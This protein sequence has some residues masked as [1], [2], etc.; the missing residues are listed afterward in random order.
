MRAGFIITLTHK[1]V[2]GVSLRTMMMM[3]TPKQPFTA[4]ERMLGL[5]LAVLF[6][7]MGFAAYTRYYVPEHSIRDMNLDQ[8]LD[9]RVTEAFVETEKLAETPLYKQQF[10]HFPNAL[11]GDVVKDPKADVKAK[12]L[13]VETVAYTP[14]TNNLAS[15]GLGKP[16]F[17]VQQHMARLALDA[18]DRKL[19]TPYNLGSYGCAAAIWEYVV[20]PSLKQAY[21]TKAGS[22][23]AAISHTQVFLNY[24][25]ANKLGKVT[26]VPTFDL[27]PDK[28][29]PG[30]VIIGIKK[31]S[32]DHHMLVAVDVDW[33]EVTDE[34]T[35]KVVPLKR[36]G[37]T[38]AY[39]G[40]T[41]LPQFGK[42]HFRIQEFASHLG[43]LN[44]HHGAINSLSENNYYDK[45]IV[46]TFAP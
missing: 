1:T 35:G 28:T 13:G 43:F 46:M 27:T 21:P 34:A 17:N 24:Y 22:I 32:G 39:A 45:F 33:G 41:G 44:T 26:T 29:P 14:S 10:T 15:T 3:S 23:P 18:H 11:S 30:T 6:I 8:Q 5:G 2:A 12:N 37:I 20:K 19:K 40:N 36:D 4:S 42:P 9:Y 16:Q 7:G 25:T 31:G 38:D